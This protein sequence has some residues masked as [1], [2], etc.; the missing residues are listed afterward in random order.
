MGIR[1][2]NVDGY[3]TGGA[4]RKKKTV[5]EKLVVY[6]R[7]RRLKEGERDRESTIERGSDSFM[8]VQY[9]KC[10]GKGLD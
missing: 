3:I 5:E 8:E 1:E 10:G 6:W 7:G 9:G 4:R 2:E